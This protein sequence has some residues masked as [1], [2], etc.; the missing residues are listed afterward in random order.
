MIDYIIIGFICVITSFI[1]INF[2][3]S[4]TKRL[5]LNNIKIYIIAFIIG[6][7]VHFITEYC[8]IS[9]WYTNKRHLTAIKMLS[10][11]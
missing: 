7:V 2:I 3:I 6:V 1:I 9:K 11:D 5:E 8:E 4:K 10:T